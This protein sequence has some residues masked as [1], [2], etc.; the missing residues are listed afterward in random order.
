MASIGLL[1]ITVV[2]TLKNEYLIYKDMYKEIHNDEITF[3]C[4]G[5]PS[6]R[7]FCHCFCC[8]VLL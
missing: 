4:D 3:V 1:T 6:F 7:D 8:H 5:K 2:M